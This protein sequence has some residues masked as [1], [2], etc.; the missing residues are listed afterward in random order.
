MHNHLCMQTTLI[1]AQEAAA[2]LGVDKSTLTRWAKAGKIKA[3]KAP[4]SN[5]PYLFR[6]AEVH[7]VAAERAEADAPESQA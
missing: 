1:G 6:P 5:G 2:L 7:R 4:G 3:V